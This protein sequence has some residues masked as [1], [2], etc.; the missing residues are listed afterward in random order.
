MDGWWLEAVGWIGS[1]VL[2]WSLLQSQLRRL[3]VINLIGS[4]VLAGYNFAIGV[5]P[6]VGLNVVLAAINVGHLVRMSRERHDAAVYEVLEVGGDDEYLRHV[7]RVHEAD[8]RRFNPDF[9]HDPFSGDP[10]Y[11]VLKGDAMVGVVLMRDLGDGRAQLLLDYVTPP[12]RDLS[13]GEFV[14]GPDGPF[15]SRGFRRVLMPPGMVDP[16]Y[17]RLGFTKDG[18]AYVL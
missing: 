16:Y 5:W 12:Y 14:F 17:E 11:L 4:V 10:S 8:I 1:A 9:V 18:D 7:L 3:R 2:V 6:M 13:P 15:R